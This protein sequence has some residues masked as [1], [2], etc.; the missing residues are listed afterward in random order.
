[1]SC[2]AISRPRV[3]RSV[4]REWGTCRSG[5]ALLRVSCDGSSVSGGKRQGPFGHQEGI[6]AHHHRNMVVPAH[7]TSA[8][9]V[10]EA[11]FAFDV[12]VHT[13]RE[14]SLFQLSHQFCSRNVGFPGTEVETRGMGFVV[15]PLDDEPDFLAL[16]MR[17]P[18]QVAHSNSAEGKACRE[19]AACSFSPLD[20]LVTAL[21]DRASQLPDRLERSSMH[22][23][24]RGVYAHTVV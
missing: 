3:R 6:T 16:G 1:M 14:P 17:Y 2:R 9:V 24:L 7:P 4:G 18:V 19:H 11:K 5:R 15:S 20:S 8:L 21:R 12:F 22:D 10:I 23:L 13:F